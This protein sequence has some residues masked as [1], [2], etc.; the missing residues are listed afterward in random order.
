MTNFVSVIIP[1]FNQAHFLK[2]AAESAL[3]QDYP[4]KEVIVVNDGSSDGTRD[5][6]AGF[7]K[8]IIYME[9]S[10]R[11]LSAARNTGIRAS[12]GDYLCFLDS[13]DVL[14][15]GSISAR[16]CFLDAHP[17][18][19]M[20]CSDSLLFSDSGPKGLH[21]EIIGL[22]RNL[23]NFRWE[24][25][26]YCAKPSTVMVRRYCFEKAGYFD[27]SLVCGGEDWLMWVRFSLYFDM[28]YLNTP[29]VR[30]RIHQGNASFMTN[31][32]DLANRQAFDLAVRYERFPEYPA[33]FRS[34]LLFHRFAAAWRTEPKRA[35]IRYFAEA[36]RT[37]PPG[38]FFGLGVIRKGMHR[39][40]RRSLNSGD[41]I[42][43]RLIHE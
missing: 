17:E 25:V 29:T 33:H 18:T 8:A 9:Q 34:R 6:A 40:I 32:L 39:I 37:Y 21:S 26:E 28:A 23:E 20:V 13:D 12:K 24:T 14:N 19:G 43:R 35:A 1:C 16:A 15:P 3:N 42:K 38:I 5:V 31:K 11:G 2:E 41:P 30:R 36:L 27:E 10:N 22:P 7:G 4:A